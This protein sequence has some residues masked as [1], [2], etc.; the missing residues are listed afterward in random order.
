MI[1]SESADKTE[2]CLLE[3]GIFGIYKQLKGSIIKD[4]EAIKEGK[5]DK[6]NRTHIF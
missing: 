6:Q 4:I 3:S 1:T 2:D 5:M